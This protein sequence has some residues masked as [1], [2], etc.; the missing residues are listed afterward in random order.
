MLQEWTDLVMGFYYISLKFT[1][2]IKLLT[3]SNIHGTKKT[4]ALIMP[5]CYIAW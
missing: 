4:R 2:K 5:M 3:N 1:E